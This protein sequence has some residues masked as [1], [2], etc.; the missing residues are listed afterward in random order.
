MGNDN[1]LPLRIKRVEM[2]GVLNL[3]GLKLKRLPKRVESSNL[4]A[5]K[6]LDLSDNRLERV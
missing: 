2:T 6:Q 3:Q 4:S 5:L 1:S